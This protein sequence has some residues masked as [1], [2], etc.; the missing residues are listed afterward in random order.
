[1]TT[2]ESPGWAAGIDVERASAARMYDYAL[3]GS[4]NFAVDREAVRAAG[5][6]FPDIE[7]VARS[8]RLFLHRA[9]RFLV[10]EAGITQFL[11][12]GSGVPTVGNV[13]EIAGRVNPDTR[14]VY[15]DFDPVAVVHSRMLLEGVPGA[16]VLQADLREPAS[17]LSSRAV[18]ET[19]DLSRPVAV[20]MVA[21][22]HFIEDD[23]DPAGIID[24]FRSATVPGSYLAISHV[25]LD[26]RAE[27]VRKVGQMVY[28]STPTGVTARRR[29]TLAGLLAGYDLVDPGLVYLSQWRP[30]AGEVSA[31]PLAGNPERSATFAAVGR[32]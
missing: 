30:D 3:G 26:V 5:K 1:M 12:L 24:A 25:G 4:H 13:H 29:D 15:V 32:R 21:V 17:I 18:A 28:S 6:A 9:V 10:A 8:N 20:L 31:D 23:A 7:L 14:V 27:E 19:L 22:L 16:A 2:E 11:D